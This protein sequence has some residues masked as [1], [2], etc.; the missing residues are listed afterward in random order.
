MN[1]W[2]RFR[3]YHTFFLLAFLEVAVILLSLELHRQTFHN[4]G[5]L[6][7]AAAQA[8]ERDRWFK[9]AEQCVLELDAPGNDVFRSGEVAHERARLQAARVRFNACMEDAA[10]FGLP[11]EPIKARVN[12]MVSAAE[13]IFKRFEHAGDDR[14][15]QAQR[16]NM[17]QAASGMSRMDAQ[18]ILAMR[19]ISLLSDRTSAGLKTLLEQHEADLQSRVVYERVFI[20]SFFILLVGILW[21]GY[22]LQKTHLALEAER[23]R[24]EEE[25]RERLAVI[26]ELCS[27]V[28]HGIRNPLA[29]IRSSAQLSLE[30]G[31]LDLN[32]RSRLEDILTEGARLGDRVTG[33]LNITRADQSDF[34]FI[35]LPEVIHDAVAGLKPEL[36]R[37][38]L[39]LKVDAEEPVRVLGDRRQLEQLV[40]ELVSNAME[41]SPKGGPVHVRCRRPHSNGMAQIEVED[42]GNGVPADLRARIF[43]LF[44]TTKPSGTGIGLATVK[45][46]SRLHGG[47]VTVSDA[48]PSGARFVVTIPTTK[49]GT[50]WNGREPSA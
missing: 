6:V 42:N 14:S 30:L 9:R 3:W 22:H 40:I 31:K 39:R 35:S 47:D 20:A 2:L 10:R 11:V 45:R 12:E 27:S 15:A 23:R 41:Q 33:L 24:V 7:E 21:F 28:A 1:A 8:D 13:D 34:E 18:Q 4:A 50:A 49:N 16:E 38:D 25:R 37:L 43:D 5:R 44:F 32:S 29:A 48:T 46:I 19:E 26:G 36:R 17:L